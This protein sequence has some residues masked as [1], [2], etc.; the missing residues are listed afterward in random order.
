M[1]KN[2]FELPT[3][4]K[5]DQS[6]AL[7][8][9]TPLDEFIYHNEP[10]GEKEAAE[11]RRQLEKLIQYVVENVEPRNPT[12]RADGTTV[13]STSTSNKDENDRP[14]AC[15]HNFVGMPIIKICNKCGYVEN[16]RLSS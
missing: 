16:E 6:M 5:A 10:A 3:W 2:K 8:E 4:S 12:L 1:S 13:E 15:I 14:K 7:G 9:D 11:F